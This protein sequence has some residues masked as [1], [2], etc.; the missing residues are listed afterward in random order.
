MVELGETVLLP[1]LA[2]PPILLILQPD[3]PKEPDQLNIAELPLFIVEG[4]TDIE[5]LGAA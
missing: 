4:L 1:V 3:K 5:T 2:T